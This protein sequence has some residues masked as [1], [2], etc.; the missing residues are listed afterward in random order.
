M[1]SQTEYIVAIGFKD[2]K[3]LKSKPAL[4]LLYPSGELNYTEINGKD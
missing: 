1:F 2:S 3:Q 4:N